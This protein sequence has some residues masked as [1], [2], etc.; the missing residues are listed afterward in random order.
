MRIKRQD[1]I[2]LFSGTDVD[3]P[4]I[5]PSSLLPRSL[6]FAIVAESFRENGANNFK[7]SIGDWL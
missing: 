6:Q 7:R 5:R 1:R 4:K 3:R 2:Q